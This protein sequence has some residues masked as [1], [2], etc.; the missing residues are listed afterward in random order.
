MSAP[1]KCDG[2][3]E[4][5]PRDDNNMIVPLQ[6]CS[7]CRQ[8]FYHDRICQAKHFKQHRPICLLAS[9]AYANRK[10][11]SQQADQGFSVPKQRNSFDSIDTDS[12]SLY[13]VQQIAGKGKSVIAATSLEAGSFLPSNQDEGISPLVHPVIFQ[14]CRRT[15][16]VWCFEELSESRKQN[17]FEHSIACLFVYM[18]RT[19]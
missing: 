1:I 9:N 11:A 12:R 6:R 18:P 3:N 10:V 7:R 14:S 8:A 16:C 2:C 5:A 13:T 15:H 17:L 4:E 19:N